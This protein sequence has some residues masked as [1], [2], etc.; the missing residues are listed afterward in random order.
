MGHNEEQGDR[1][2]L[3]HKKPATPLAHEV[4]EKG[5]THLIE[6]RG[7]EELEVIGQVDKGEEADGRI[8]E[9]IFFQP[10]GER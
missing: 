7:P 6:D 10:N 3:Q 8:A 1:E 2:G 4:C 9:T 5:Q